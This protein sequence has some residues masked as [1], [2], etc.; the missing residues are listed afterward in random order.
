MSESEFE[1]VRLW[2]FPKRMIGQD[3]SIKGFARG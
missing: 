1:D 2:S 3:D